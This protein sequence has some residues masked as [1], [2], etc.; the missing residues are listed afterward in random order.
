MSRSVLIAMPVA[1]AFA[2]TML[3][4]VGTAQAETEQ[5]DSSLFPNKIELDGSSTSVDT[6]LAPGTEVCIKA[7]TGTVI[8][9]VDANGFIT[10][11]AIWN[12]PGNALLG[13]SYY[14]YG[15]ESSGS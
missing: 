1:A 4:G 13:I 2:G 7:G 12:K 14:A 9:T 8:V 6:G 10:Q 3:L 5:C 15:E 11:N